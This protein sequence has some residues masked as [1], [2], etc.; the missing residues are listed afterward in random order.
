MARCSI[1]SI[2]PASGISAAASPVS[3]AVF[4]QWSVSALAAMRISQAANGTPRHSN[5]GRLASACS[6][7][8]DVM[9]SAVGAVAHA[10]A[11]EAVHTLDVAVVQLLEPRRVGLGR[12]DERPLVVLVDG[13]CHAHSNSCFHSQ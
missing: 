13:D 6:N 3:R 10:P 12:R 4:R 2:S 5:F 11:D 1:A 8:A 7:T 9:S